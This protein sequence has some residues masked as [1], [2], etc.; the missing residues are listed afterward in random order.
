[1]EQLRA[2]I[3]RFLF[4]N[5]AIGSLYAVPQWNVQL[6]SS[7]GSRNLVVLDDVWSPLVLEQLI[8]K[9]T[10]CKTLFVSRFKFPTIVNDATYEVELLGD[11]YA[12][13]LFCL[14]AFGQKFIPPAAN[15]SL[16]KQVSSKP[17]R[18]FLDT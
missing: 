4:G 12:I 3:S 17:L 13:S 10:G 16:V 9:T 7:N 8:F 11:D 14:S 6:T 15:E 5:E 1:M 2:K 18:Y